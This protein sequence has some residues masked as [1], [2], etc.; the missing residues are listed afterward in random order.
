MCC[1]KSFVA[2]KLIFVS[3]VIF[4]LHRY[5]PYIVIKNDS[6]VIMRQGRASGTCTSSG[7]ALG[8]GE[9]LQAQEKARGEDVI[10]ND[11]KVIMRAGQLRSSGTVESFGRA[12]GYGEYL[13]AQEKARGEDVI[14]NDS[15]VIMRAGQ[16]RSSGTV[17]S[18]GRGSQGYAEYLQAQE[19]AR[20]EDVVKN[21]SSVIMRA[22]Q[23]RSSGT[24][25][26]FGSRT[27]GYAEM[28]QAQEAARGEEVIKN[29]SSV[30]MRSSMRGDDTVES[31]GQDYKSGQK[32]ALNNVIKSGS[33]RTLSV[34]LNSTSVDNS[35]KSSDNSL[36]DELMEVLEQE[37]RDQLTEIM[38][39]KSLN[40]HERRAALEE[41][42]ERYAD[43]AENL[44]S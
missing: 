6:S 2:A 43:L 3:N 25:E 40:K 5:I 24:V 14:K 20:G 42:K 17:E 37:R 35:F 18:F 32:E 26:S 10:K 12:L 39:N 34:S 31:Y 27:Q 9:Y 41:V 23:F 8:Y 4:C 13:Q 16:L 22:G 1:C 30:I 33:N 44:L 21:D 15:K 38:N 7:R 19:K 11:S 28:L 36:D 29:N